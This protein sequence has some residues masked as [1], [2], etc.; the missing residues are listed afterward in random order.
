VKRKSSPQRQQRGR[1]GS[2]E[3][4]TKSTARNRCATGGST[5]EVAIE[6]NVEVL[7]PS[8]SD[9]FR[10]TSCLWLKAELKLDLNSH[11]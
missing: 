4:G 5:L 8:L 3:E 10:M 1:G 9:G 2:G 7:Q 6:S 11:P